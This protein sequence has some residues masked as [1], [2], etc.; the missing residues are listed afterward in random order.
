[1]STLTRTEAHQGLD[2]AMTCRAHNI[3][4][5]AAIFNPTPE[6]DSLVEE[7]ASLLRHGVDPTVVANLTTRCRQ[8]LESNVAEGN[9][10]MHLA[11]VFE[12]HIHRTL[13]TPV[14]ERATIKSLAAR[15]RDPL[16]V[17]ASGTTDGIAYFKACCAVRDVIT[18]VPAGQLLTAS[19]RHELRGKRYG[20]L[21]D[22]VGACA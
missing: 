1:M 16:G 10:E 6:V 7:I 21:A 11:G 20:V 14:L 4:Q 5:T 12:A 13:A 3:E 19:M 15:L 18:S 2:V 8:I 17:I 22:L 9:G